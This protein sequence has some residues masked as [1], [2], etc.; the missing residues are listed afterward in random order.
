MQMFFYVVGIFLLGYGDIYPQIDKKDTLKVGSV[1]P[2]FFLQTLSGD[3]FYLSDYCGKLR[4]PWKSNKQYVVILSFF[5]T[6]CQPCLKEI[7]ELEEVAAKYAG[8]NLKVFLIDVNE[9]AEVVGPFVKKQ[10]FKLPVL[11]DAY[12]VVAKKYGATKLPRY[13]LIDKNGKILLMGEGYSADFK[14]RLNEN[15]AR[16]FESNP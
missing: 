8:K 11:L 6:W 9:K 5:A 12:S 1:A 3:E 7:P 16:L 15:L 10:G 2:T 14:E 4:Q 13:F